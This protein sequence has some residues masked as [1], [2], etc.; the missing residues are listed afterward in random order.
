MGVPPQSRQNACRRFRDFRRFL[1]SCESSLKLRTTCSFCLFERSLDPPSTWCETYRPMKTLLV[2][3]LCCLSSVA[4]NSDAIKYAPRQ[5]LHVDPTPGTEAVLPMMFL[6][7][8]KQHLEFVP[9]HQ[10]K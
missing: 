5:I 10:I 1:L 7:E 4:Q 6:T 9:V 2:L 8:G 3:L